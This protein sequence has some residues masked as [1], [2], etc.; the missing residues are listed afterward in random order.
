[1]QRFQ[2]G[3]HQGASVGGKQPGHAYDRRMSTMGGRESVVHVKVGER[4]QLLRETL[5]VGLFFRVEAKV[6]EQ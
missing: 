2:L 1:M 5:V 6:F 3:Q 4:R